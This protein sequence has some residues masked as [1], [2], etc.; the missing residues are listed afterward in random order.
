MQYKAIP[1]ENMKGLVDR[2]YKES[3]NLGNY[4]SARD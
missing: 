4:S 1:Q 3:R 2:S